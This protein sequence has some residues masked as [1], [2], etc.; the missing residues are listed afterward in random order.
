MV[1]NSLI[2]LEFQMLKFVHCY[3]SSAPLHKVMKQWL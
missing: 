1:T 3:E 2:L